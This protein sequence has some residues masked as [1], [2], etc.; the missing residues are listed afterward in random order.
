MVKRAQYN[1]IDL[2]CGCGGL[3]KGFEMAG[4]NIMLGIDNNE[5]ALKTFEHNHKNSKA[6]NADLSDPKTFD[7]INNI[8]G[9]R[10]I[11]VIIGGP[12]C[13][14]FSLTGKRQFDDERNKLY[15]AMIETV[16]R[17]RPKAFVI[18]NVPGMASLYNGEVH[19]EII[20][21]F[22]CMGYS[23][24]SKV[25][26]AADYGVPQIRQRLFFVGIC[27]STQIFEFPKPLL[28]PDNYITCAEAIDDLPSLENTLGADES[29]YESGPHNNYQKLM[30]GKCNVLY[31][32]KSIDHKEFVKQTIALVPDGGNWKDLP[33]GV[34]ESRKFHMAWT[35]YRSDK[36]SRTIDTGH[37]NNFHY[38][39]NRCPTVRESARLQS[40]PDDFVFLGTKT[41]QDRQV[42]NAVPCLMAK[43]IG[44][45]ILNYINCDKSH[46][47]SKYNTIDLFAGCGGLMDGFM[48]QGDF[49]TLAC[50]EWER[51]PC[52]TLAK[53]LKTRWNH[54]NS[55]EE[56]I[57]FDI[58]RTEELING[59]DDPK[60]GKSAGLNALIKGKSIDVII[61]GPPC[62]AYSLAGRI[63]DPNGMRD[64]YRNYLFESYVRLLKYYNPKIFIFENVVGMLSAAPDGTPIVEKIQRSFKDAGYIVASDFKKTVFNVSDF[65]IPQQRKRVIVLGIRQDLLARKK[66]NWLFDDY[67]YSENLINSFYDDIMPSFKTKTRTVSDAISDLP[68]LFP[69]KSVIRK[70]GQKFSHEPVESV[71]W[72]NHIPRYHNERDQKVFRLLADDIKSGRNQYTSIDSLKELYTEVTG[73]VSNIHKYYVLRLNEPSNTIPA[74]LF[75]DGMRHIHPDPEQARSITVREAARLQS[76]DDD[77]EFLGPNMAQYKMVGN[78]VPPAFAKIV[79]E[80]VSRLLTIIKEK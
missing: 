50:V 11:D 53:R 71:G 48:Q 66:K 54:I 70:N 13:Q 18:E 32:H 8:V 64:D 42:G 1:V 56:V 51:Y 79:A 10:S 43:A 57:R 21:R 27:D 49:N 36:P 76:F 35:R 78:A 41:Q 72:L 59:F 65:G 63:R 20:R 60:Y 55:D 30:R 24:N 15:L 39:W 34:G 52:D 58:Q 26:C 28:T 44:V 38:K 6:L 73:H 9:K 19:D 3:S 33:P 40:F 16:R 37:R 80:A 75:K 23:V 25:L 68:K 31:N 46:D 2:F 7:E 62:Q 17:F 4:Y 47:K 69:A 77:F 12:P 5:A 29:E 61:G 74:H 22:Q 14:G 45:Q 67:D